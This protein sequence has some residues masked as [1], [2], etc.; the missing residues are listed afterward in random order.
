[1]KTGCSFCGKGNDLKPEAVRDLRKMIQNILKQK[2]AG[3]KDVA[4]AVRISLECAHCKRT[5]S[6][7]LTQ[8]A[9]TAQDN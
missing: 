2:K 3:I 6:V 4:G 7:A 8:E 1:M 9:F 5:Y